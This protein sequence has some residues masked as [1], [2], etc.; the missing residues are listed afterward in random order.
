MYYY[1][2]N[3]ILQI[4][5]L[6][7]KY[8]QSI[9]ASMPLIVK[10]SNKSSLGTPLVA[11]LHLPYRSW[12]MSGIKMTGYNTSNQPVIIINRNFPDNSGNYHIY[13]HLM[14]NSDK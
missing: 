3:I 6:Q 7:F 2:W 9:S 11:G 8:R 5:K 13:F 4:H 14:L 12:G 10:T 1:F